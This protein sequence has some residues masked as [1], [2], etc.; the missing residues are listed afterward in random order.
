MTTNEKISFLYGQLHK[1]ID[2]MDM[3]V[4]GLMQ[5]HE[6]DFISAYRVLTSLLTDIG[7]YAACL[8]RAAAYQEIYH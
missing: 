3:I 4:D 1:S 6:A 7:S 2:T 8:A 5:R